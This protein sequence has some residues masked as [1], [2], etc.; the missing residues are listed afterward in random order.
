MLDDLPALMRHLIIALIS[1]AIAWGSAELIP[2]LTRQG[3]VAA[4]IG[5]LLTVVLTTI[6][7]LV[8]QY[9]TGSKGSDRTVL[10]KAQTGQ[11][12]NGDVA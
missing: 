12:T 11:P 2:A 9:G 7:P 3:G 5:A 8:R 4:L 1:S 6:L 10:V